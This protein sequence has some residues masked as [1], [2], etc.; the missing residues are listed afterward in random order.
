MTPAPSRRWTT[1]NWLQ[2]VTGLLIG[3][4]L[5]LAYVGAALFFFLPA[6]TIPLFGLASMLFMFAC[7]AWQAQ[8][9]RL[10][11]L[12]TVIGLVSAGTATVMLWRW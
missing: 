3:A 6:A 9:A 5:Y 2:L 4:L 12:F 1:G 7:V 10:T 11:V 8:R